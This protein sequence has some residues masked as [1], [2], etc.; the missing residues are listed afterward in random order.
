MPIVRVELFPGRDGVQKEFLARAIA[1]ALAEIAGSSREGVHTIF[2]SI[3]AE[4]WAIG[5][6][7]AANAERKPAGRHAPAVVAAE[8]VRVKPGRHEEYVAWR[9]NSLYPF[10][11]AREGFVSCT[12]LTVDGHPDEYMILEKWVSPEARAV[13]AA[14]PRADRL[15]DEARA[16]LEPSAGEDLSGRA[17]DVFGGRR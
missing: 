6:R 4:D 1:D 2:S 3:S 14:D 12:L 15:R 7:L 8:R 11:A 13:S 9:R 17:V 10:L 5:P 16:W